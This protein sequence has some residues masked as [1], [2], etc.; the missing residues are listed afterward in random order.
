MA[1]LLHSYLNTNSHIQKQPSAMKTTTN[2]Y[3]NSSA[4]ISQ[5]ELLNLS[6]SIKPNKTLTTIINNLQTTTY[7][8]NT[9]YLPHQKP[10]PANINQ[11]KSS[12]KTHDKAIG[13]RQKWIG[14]WKPIFSICHEKT[15]CQGIQRGTQTLTT[16]YGSTHE[17]APCQASIRGQDNNGGE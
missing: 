2:N 16:P 1:A 4:T 12:P 11:A 13:K 14:W 15:G 10:K 7:Q 5:Q 6:P 3:T 8:P 17:E 9:N